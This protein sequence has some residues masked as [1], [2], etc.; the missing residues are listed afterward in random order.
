MN[1]VYTFVN[2]VLLGT[3]PILWAALGCLFAH[4][5]GI[6]HVDTVVSAT[7]SFYPGT[8]RPHDVTIT[9]ESGDVGSCS[10]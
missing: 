3:T 4:R 8:V 2:S 1:E 9:T 10:H 7:G 5:A 6:Y